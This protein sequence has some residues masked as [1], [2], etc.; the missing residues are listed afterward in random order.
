LCPKADQRGFTLVE[1]IVVIVILGI[2]A[3]IA[4]PALT[5][6]IEKAKWEGLRSQ[7]RNQM[8][9]FQ[10][11]IAEEFADGGGTPVLYTASQNSPDKVFT[12]ISTIGVD[13]MTYRFD[14]LTDYGIEVYAALVGDD[15]FTNATDR[16]YMSM[17]VDSNGAIAMYQYVCFQY[18]PGSERPTLS[19]SYWRSVD[20]ADPSFAAYK[21]SYPTY[22]DFYTLVTEGFN[23][24]AY[25]G[26]ATP[27]YEK[28]WSSS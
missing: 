3:A 23:A 21:Y 28:I 7:A 2:L 13:N 6:Y 16:R 27:R 11:L 12:N 14:G 1:L 17:L 8:V 19:L 22:S 20:D 4:V 18:F 26:S 24:C 15:S 25:G 5:G 9:A 10:S